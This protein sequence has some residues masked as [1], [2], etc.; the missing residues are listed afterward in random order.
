MDYEMKE[1]KIKLSESFKV[2]HSSKR[3]AIIKAHRELLSKL[4]DSTYFMKMDIEE[5]N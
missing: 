4:L 5:L 1:F 3:G 2:K